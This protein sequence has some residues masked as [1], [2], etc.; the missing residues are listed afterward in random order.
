MTNPASCV[1]DITSR[2]KLHPR[3]SHWRT[4]SSPGRQNHCVPTAGKRRNQRHP[5]R[6]CRHRAVSSQ[7]HLRT[8][9]LGSHRTASRW[10]RSRKEITQWGPS[11]RQTDQA[12]ADT[13]RK[14]RILADSPQMARPWQSPGWLVSGRSGSPLGYVSGEEIRMGGGHQDEVTCLAYAPDGKLRLG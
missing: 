4:W 8:S 6:E 7:D 12:S 2:K 11:I 5:G 14:I 10:S 3:L 13:L 9:L 1:Q